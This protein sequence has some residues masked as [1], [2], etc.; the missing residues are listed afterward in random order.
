MTPEDSDLEALFDLFVER[1]IVAEERLD[2]EELC[3]AAPHLL[4]PLRARV[5]QLE[6][7][8]GLLAARRRPRIGGALGRYQIE[9]EIERG[10]MS[11]LY[12]ARDTEAGR[13]VAL[14]LFP[15]EW[16][17]DEELQQRFRREADILA[18]LAHP[19]I[20]RFYSLEQVDGFHFLTT[21][22]LGGPTLAALV[23]PGGLR[24]EEVM[25]IALAVSAALEAAHDCGVAHR[26]LKPTNGMYARN[27]VLK[28]LDFGLARVGGPG[29][30]L[31]LTGSLVGT[32]PYMAPEQLLGSRG[33]AVSDVY[34]FGILLYELAS[35][36]RPFSEKFVPKL[37]RA[38]FEHEPEPLDGLIGDAT[39][40]LADL[41]M[42]CLRRE[43]QQRPATMAQIRKALI[44][45]GIAPQPPERLLQGS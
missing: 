22:L 7:V 39:G 9:Q 2:L 11:V 24:A 23:R 35:G 10:A 33:D 20:V 27:G 40:R 34:S 26:D 37:I 12:R 8:T 43:R 14:K 13:H 18:R 25:A 38:V 28:L 5:R 31:T 36:R 42:N 3:A 15:P 45:T 6:E 44:D 41:I 21:E 32:V 16:A 19:H 1:L 29:D 17:A 4:A 30:S